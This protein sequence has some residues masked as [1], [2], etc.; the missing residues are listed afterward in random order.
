MKR[1]SLV[2]MLFLAFT[3]FMSLNAQW[4]RTYGGSY[5]DFGRYIKQT[6][7]GGYIVAGETYSFH[8]GPE[9]VWI[10]KL[11]S[12][13]AIEWQ[14]IYGGSDRD[15]A[16]SIQQTSDGGYIVAG[17]TLS[18]GAGACDIWILKLTSIGAIEWQHTYGGSGPDYAYSIQQTS[19][20][21]YIVAGSV[22]F[23]DPKE[24]EALVLKLDSYGNIEW[25][26]TYGGWDSDCAYS[27]QQTS[28]GGYVVAGLTDS[29]GAGGFD[30]IWVLK[31]TLI[32]S[33]EWQRTYGTSSEHFNY[34][35]HQSSDGGYILAGYTYSFS[36]GY[37]DDIWILKLDLKGD[38]EWQRSYGGEANDYAYSIQQTSDG[39]YIVAGSAES[40]SVGSGDFFVLKL[41]SD[42]DIDPS[43]GFIGISDAIVLDSNVIPEDTDVTPTDTNITPQDTSITPQDTDA[44]VLLLCEAR[45]YSLKISASIGGTTYPAPNTY[46]H[47]NRTQVSVTAVPSSG[48]QFSGWSGNASGLTNRIRITMEADKSITA[49]FKKKGLCFIATAAFNSPFH[50]YVK[51]LRDFRDKYLMPGR[52]GRK[53]VDLYYKYSPFAANFIAKHKALKVLVRINLLPLIA[54]SYSMVHLGPIPTTTI[55]VFIFISLILLISFYR[56]KT[57]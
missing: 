19:D 6:S 7:D 46:S 20:G 10:L 55:L 32:G 40:F 11:S 48:Y 49:N 34:S 2:L 27:I 37:N 3:S 18:F 1:V 8:T 36:S 43:C 12:T 47:Y 9:D 57:R 28:D 31:L 22:F 25:Q 17:F 21:G 44:T 41:Y 39:G 29:F 23:Y 56:R 52:I 33:I 38:I 13:G 51:I 16:N 45:K 14:K 4:A 35:I 54:F 24:L 26:R 30:N 53:I 5:Y 42:G 15:C 50:P